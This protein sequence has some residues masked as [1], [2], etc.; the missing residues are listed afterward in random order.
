MVKLKKKKKTTCQR[1]YRCTE[2]RFKCHYC[3][4]GSTKTF[5]VITI[6]SLTPN[7][8]KPSQL[9][10]QLPW[11]FLSLWV[12]REVI[13][14]ESVFCVFLQISIF[15]YCFVILP[16]LT[17]G[18]SSVLINCAQNRVNKPGH[19]VFIIRNK[20]SSYIIYIVFSYVIC[21]EL[22]VSIASHLVHNSAEICALKS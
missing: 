11:R 6:P 9:I 3:G 2:S 8:C 7:P 17:F 15:A 13:L 19:V 10:S 4:E 21:S 20:G 22:L 1:F 16:V 14:A 12:M 18:F 5:I